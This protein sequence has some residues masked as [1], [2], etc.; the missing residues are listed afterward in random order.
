MVALA[1]APALWKCSRTDVAP[2]RDPELAICKHRTPH[3]LGS[4]LK[5]AGGSSIQLLRGVK[6]AELAAANGGVAGPC[7]ASS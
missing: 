4:K 3:F 6:A 1:R 2:A 5:D 7:R